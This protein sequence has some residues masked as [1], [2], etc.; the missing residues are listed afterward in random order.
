[1]QTAENPI[2]G[3]SFGSKSHA[4]I[5][6]F[7]SNEGAAVCRLFVYKLLRRKP[8]YFVL[9]STET[10]DELRFFSHEISGTIIARFTTLLRTAL[11]LFA[12]ANGEGHILPK[13]T[14]GA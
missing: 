2:N 10:L 12:A 11:L 9:S 1:L 3:P 4:A 7:L 13:S 5:F 14:A 6:L 8:H